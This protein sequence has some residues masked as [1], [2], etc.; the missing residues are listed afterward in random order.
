MVATEYPSSART[1]HIFEIIH[2]KNIGV[3]EHKKFS[4]GR[5]GKTVCYYLDPGLLYCLDDRNSQ[6]EIILHVSPQGE[7]SKHSQGSGPEDNSDEFNP[8][9]PLD[10]LEDVVEGELKVRVERVGELGI[11]IGAYYNTSFQKY[12]AQV[13]S[14][15]GFT[16]F[17]YDSFVHLVNPHWQ[18]K[19]KKEKQEVR[20]QKI[21]Q[22]L[23]NRKR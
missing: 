21:A 2:R 8:T 3:D 22:K 15:D 10:P 20:E 4:L 11:S 7:T 6:E 9:N 17:K 5:K 13:G 19:K 1:S 16:G 23:K 18:E 12:L 14:G